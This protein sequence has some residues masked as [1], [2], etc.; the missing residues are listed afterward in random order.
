MTKLT[1]INPNEIQEGDLMVYLHGEAPSQVAEHVTRCSFCADQVEQLRMVDAQLLSTFYRDACPSPQALADLSLNRLSATEKLRVAAHVRGCAACTKETT[2]VRD[3]TDESPPSLLA[4]L[5]ETLALALV[6]RQIT[7]AAVPVRGQGWQGRFETDDLIVT[8][9]T[10]EGNL[11][12]RVRRR[13]APSSTDYRGQAWLLGKKTAKEDVPRSRIDRSGRFR[14]TAQ[15][16]GSYEM[17]LQV[18]EQSM[19]LEMVR[20]E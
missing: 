8:L 15:E 13:D 2:S 6:A 19:A 7:P 17:L 12:G 3:L 20:I 14:F 16:T 9:L 18:N 10:Q 1:C 4:R 11:T 5:R